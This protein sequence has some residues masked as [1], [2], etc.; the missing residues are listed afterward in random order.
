MQMAEPL[1]GVLDALR[2]AGEETRLRI[3]HVL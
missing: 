1:D 2:A 3:L